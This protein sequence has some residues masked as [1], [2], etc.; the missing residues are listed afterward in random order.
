MDNGTTVTLYHLSRR[1]G[2]SLFVHPF[3]KA[4]SILEIDSSTELRGRY[5]AEPRVE[6][7]TLFRNE[8]YR[9][10]EQDV[11]N[12]INERRFIPRFLL[13]AGAFVLIYLFLSLIIRDPIPL[14]DEFLI[15]GGVGIF[16]F[17]VVGRRFEQ[18]KTA[19]DRRVTLRAKVDNAVFSEDPFV[20]DLE[21]IFHDLE[22]LP[23]ETIEVADERTIDKARAL[24]ETH[25]QDTARLISYLRTFLSNSDYRE[26]EKQMKRGRLSGKIGEA[27]K[28]GSLVPATVMLFY[29]LQS[30]S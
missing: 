10:I 20:H 7:L 14:V 29:L 2:T 11:R 17:I 13:A 28:H 23:K 12:W 26:L 5:G 15:A 18:S 6:S 9:R 21:T 3:S 4:G 25:P 16:V 1:D 19:G 27:V 24:R 30:V 22:Q 8:L